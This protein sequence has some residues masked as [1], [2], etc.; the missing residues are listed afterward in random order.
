MLDE[1]PWLPTYIEIEGP[2][3]AAIKETAHKLGFDWADAKFGSVDTAYLDEYTKMTERESIGDLPK[4]E[5]GKS[6]PN[7]LQVRR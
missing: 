1:W 6:V 2:T 3:E 7:W 4:V 5:F